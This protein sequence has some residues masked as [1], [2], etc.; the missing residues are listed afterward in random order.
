M[1]RSVISAARSSALKAKSRSSESSS[2]H[3]HRAHELHPRLVDRET[4]RGIDDLVALVHVRLQRV[5][6]RGLGAGRDHDARGAHL[7]PPRPRDVGGDRLA[8]GQDS[9]RIAVPRPARL[10]RLHRHAVQV[11]G[12]AEV[13]R[14]QVEA[15]HVEAHVDAALD[16]VAQLEGVLCA[17][18]AHAAG[19]DGQGDLLVGGPQVFFGGPL[20]APTGN[21]S[22]AANMIKDKRQ[23]A[24]AGARPMKRQASRRT[25]LTEMAAGAVVLPAALTGG[26][27]GHA[28]VP[29][30]ARRDRPV[31]SIRPGRA[32]PRWPPTPPPRA[33]RPGGRWSAPSSPSPRSASDERGQPLPLAPVGGGARGGADPRHRPRLFLQQPG[34]VPRPHRAVPGRRG[35]AARRQRR[36]DRDRPATPANPTTRSTTA[37]T[38]ARA[39]KWSCGIRTTR[40]T[41]WRGTCVRHASGSR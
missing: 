13:G 11:R 19:D 17:Q 32:S 25:F 35:R 31:A 30:F 9:G 18:L 41:T 7:D 36:R 39:T 4:R 21:R 34:Q 14:A 2:G 3:R 15:D 37:S 33:T 6:D 8:E 40:P 22:C 5:A 26:P 10:E 29:P 20:G 27:R 23:S 1:V 12:A 28:G 16:V 24:T 38:C